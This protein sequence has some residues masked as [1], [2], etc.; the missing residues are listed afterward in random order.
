[1]KKGNGTLVFLATCL[2]V[3]APVY[4]T[5]E[6]PVVAEE[7]MEEYSLSVMQYSSLV[8]ASTLASL[9]LSVALGF[10]ADRFGI[11]PV[12]LACCAIAFAGALARNWATGFAQLM[13]CG[14]MIGVLS[15]S[16]NANHNK[17]FSR[18]L[19]SDK[20][21]RAVGVY[22][23][24]TTLT[25]AIASATAT[26]FPSLTSAFTFAAAFIAVA[27]VLWALIVPGEGRKASEE[28]AISAETAG[29]DDE[30]DGGGG[31]RTCLTC[32]SIWAIGLMLASVS[33]SLVI[34]GSF[35]PSM[36]SSEGMDSTSA[37]YCSALVSVGSFMG[38]ILVPMIDAKL[39]R[40]KPLMVFCIVA[41]AL[42]GAA[43]ALLSPSPLMFLVLFLAGFFLGGS[44]PLPLTMVAKIPG[45]GEENSGTALGMARTVQLGIATVLPSYILA[46]IL[47]TSYRMYFVAGAV[48]L[49]VGAVIAAVLPDYSDR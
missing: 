36:L 45:I 33:S 22:S 9:F 37:G 47:E 40:S 35:L 11:K 7:L 3:V 49:L 24:V 16:L 14:I 48:F 41:G 46:P 30:Q 32:G 28:G 26:S 4:A 10:M 25:P 17:I 34:Y 38:A 18:F 15:T 44:L 27:A 8:S 1:M 39:K 13:A 5:Y 31:L 43:T 6:L 12:I 21:S 29:A 23:A 19:P 20:L 2:L 42:C